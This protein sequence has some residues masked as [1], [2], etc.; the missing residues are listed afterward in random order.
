[1]LDVGHPYNR[2]PYNMRRFEMLGDLPHFAADAIMT[3]ANRG[4]DWQ[5]R[6]RE[7]CAVTHPAWLQVE[8]DRLMAPKQ[9]CTEALP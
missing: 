9:R 2:H 7:L 4:H 5:E 3:Y 1:M 8:L 6:R